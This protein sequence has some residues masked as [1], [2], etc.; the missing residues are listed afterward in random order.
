M[1]KIKNNIW[2][3]S[4]IITY[5]FAMNKNIFGAQNNARKFLC[6]KIYSYNI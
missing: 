2:Y 5:L 1:I 4:L 6:I 3:V